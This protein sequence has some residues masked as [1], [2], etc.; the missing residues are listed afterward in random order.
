MSVFLDDDTQM[1]S[2]LLADTEQD[3][4]SVRLESENRICVSSVSQDKVSD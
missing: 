2:L 4:M 3:I 1:V